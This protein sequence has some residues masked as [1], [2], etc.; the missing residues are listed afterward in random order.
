MAFFRI[1]LN[2]VIEV[3]DDNLPYCEI[4]DLIEFG[5]S[6]EMPSAVQI[7]PGSRFKFTRLARPPKSKTR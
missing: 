6:R 3:D 5:L 7:L 2:Y 4:N 1:Q